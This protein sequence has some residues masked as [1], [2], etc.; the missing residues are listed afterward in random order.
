VAQ[1]SRRL[2]DPAILLALKQMM[3][4]LRQARATDGGGPW[5]ATANALAGRPALD[6]SNI[7]L[8]FY[9]NSDALGS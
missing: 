8:I 1:A 4:P 5:A 7:G 6:L 3:I 2:K 9:L